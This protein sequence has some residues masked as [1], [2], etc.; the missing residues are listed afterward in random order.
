M[1]DA[2]KARRRLGDAARQPFLWA[3]LVLVGAAIHST[4]TILRQGWV[5]LGDDAVVAG[6][7]R[8]TAGG[9]LRL[10][11]MP[12]SFWQFTGTDSSHP[13]PL[14]FAW[15]APWVLVLGRVEGAAWG[16]TVLNIAMV[17]GC[18]WVGAR[19]GGRWVAL[20]VLAAAS[21]AAIVSVGAYV[22]RPLNA[23][24][25]ALPVFAVLILAWATVCRVRH[26]PLVL[27][28]VASFATQAHL[29]YAPLALGVALPFLVQHLHR[30]IRLGPG[31]ARSLTI[32]WGGVAVALWSGPLLDVLLHRGG[33]VAALAGA[34][35]KGAVP[36]RG[37]TA[38]SRFLLSLATPMPGSR[39]AADV[40][41][42]AVQPLAVGLLVPV[43]VLFVWTWRRGPV[44]ARRALPVLAIA[45]VAGAFTSWQIPTTPIEDHQVHWYHMVATFF[46][47]VVVLCL[48][49]W[50][51]R[52][53][54]ARA[55]T[56]T[57]PALAIVVLGLSAIH[58][59]SPPPFHPDIDPN[60]FLEDFA[61]DARK[62]VAAAMEADRR[63]LLVSERAVPPERLLQVLIADRAVSGDP[64][65][66]QATDYWGTGRGLAKDRPVDGIVMVTDARLARDVPA[67]LV[68]GRE[69]PAAADHRRLASDL[70]S[71]V[72]EA[73]E[74]TLTDEGSAR[75]AE[76]VD[77]HLPTS[78]EQL[79]RYRSAPERLAAEAPGSLVELFQQGWVDTSRLPPGLADRVAG[80]HG[81]GVW[82]YAIEGDR[83]DLVS[84]GPDQLFLSRLGCEP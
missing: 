64:I 59:A 42:G 58:L 30:Q 14:L 81:A 35:G 26:A 55:T 57:V 20:G 7:A 77:G 69:S 23:T 3:S 84:D 75:L 12:N 52:T 28:V 49:G 56:L 54:L 71:F 48:V 60:H 73:G 2:G 38:A 51:R 15:L 24:I 66:V 61:G 65:A 25:A 79:D 72:R 37:P 9:E 18:G 40:F 10:I 6:L 83:V 21:Y 80:A 70:A 43:V 27:L 67:R 31:R 53:P 19:L 5:P 78:C 74:L 50:L 63:Y 44:L 62:P 33:N 13:G 16:A 68:V 29:V 1:R 11:G 47:L 39:A 34:L 4:A 17:V 41:G 82:V 32:R 22:H 46:W 45:L 8:L 36:V 76:A